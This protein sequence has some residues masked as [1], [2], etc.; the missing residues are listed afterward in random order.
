MDRQRAE[1]LHS[2]QSALFNTLHSALISLDLN[3]PSFSPAASHLLPVTPPLRVPT[4]HGRP[5][6]QPLHSK[7][8]TREPRTSWPL[9]TP[10]RPRAPR[11]RNMQEAQ[12]RGRVRL[13][14]TPGQAVSR[15]RS[16]PFIALSCLAFEN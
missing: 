7:E 11:V 14:P 12:A 4:N 13:P 6:L 3:H 1:H 15:T 16:T 10:V 5:R 2:A 8:E 9:L